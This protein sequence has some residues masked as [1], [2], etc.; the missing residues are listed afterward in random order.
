MDAIALG[1]CPFCGAEPV[2]DWRLED[3]PLLAECRHLAHVDV[4]VWQ[5]CHDSNTWHRLGG[6]MFEGFD[7]PVEWL[8]VEVASLIRGYGLLWHSGLFVVQKRS[9]FEA[10]YVRGS[11]LV[12]TTIATVWTSSL[13]RANRLLRKLKC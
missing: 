13:R 11:G 4:E 7:Y 8:Q 3:L 10:N 6:W 9:Q 12:G 1:L 5:G 2:Y